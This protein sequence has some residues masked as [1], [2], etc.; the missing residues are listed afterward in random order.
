MGIIDGIK[1]FFKP[2]ERKVYVLKAT[3]DLLRRVPSLVK[4]RLGMLESVVV[5][6]KEDIESLKKEIEKLKG[7][8]D[9]EEKILKDLLKEKTKIERTKKARRLRELFHGIP[10]PIVKTWDFKFFHDG[11]KYLKYLKGYEREET[12]R[13]EVTNLLLTD[14]R[15]SKDIYRRET[16]LPF[17]LLFEHPESFVSNVRSGVIRVRIDSK[18]VF[19]EPVGVASNPNPKT[20]KKIAE[21]KKEHEQKVAELKQEL[22][23]AY[24]QLEKAKKREEKAQMRLKDMELSNNVNDFRADLSQGALASTLTKMKGMMRDYM[25]V[26]LSSQE[27]EVNRVL[28]D[29]LNEMLI[30]AFHTIKEKTGRELPEDVK[31][32]IREKVRAEFIDNLDILHELSPRKV[33]VEKRVLPTPKPKPP[34]KPEGE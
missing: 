9:R 20:Y 22:N 11:K 31:E 2:P 14:K 23:K 17:D 32:L 24:S 15:K 5:K 28:T 16:G 18:G 3:P 25:T 1:G 29:R 6:Q 21:I 13:G 30:T 27:S 33:E 34:P 7:K 4:K 10:L 26:L 19:H 12:E 8:E